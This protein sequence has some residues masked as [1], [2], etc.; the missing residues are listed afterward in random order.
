MMLLHLNLLPWR[1]QQ[2]RRSAKIFC[3]RVYYCVSVIVGLSLLIDISLSLKLRQQHVS[4]RYL[5]KQ[6][7]RLQL[8]IVKLNRILQERQTRLAFLQALSVLNRQKLHKLQLFNYISNVLPINAY[9]NT[10]ESTAQRLLLS[11][12]ITNQTGIAKMLLQLKHFSWLKDPQLEISM[13]PQSQATIY[14]HHFII[15]LSQD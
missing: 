8:P 4:N 10:I 13:N 7:N 3:R 6:I 15:Q 9:L 11:G 12:E 1:E 5:Q 14:K 2:R